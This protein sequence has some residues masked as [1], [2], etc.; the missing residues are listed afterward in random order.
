MLVLCSKILVILVLAQ[1]VTSVE[2]YKSKRVPPKYKEIRRTYSLKEEE[3]VDSTPADTFLEK[4]TDRDTSIGNIE[5]TDDNQ[6]SFTTILTNDNGG[7]ID[8]PLKKNEEKDK[9]E[10]VEADVNDNSDQAKESID[11]IQSTE[12]E[13][14]SFTTTVKPKRRPFNLRKKSKSSE[15]DI[16]V[17]NDRDKVS[18]EKI[19][20]T[21]KKQF[22]LTTSTI[23]AKRRN[24]NLRPIRNKEDK[25]P[26]KPLETF[27]K[28][29][30]DK[31]E[32]TI[33]DKQI[34]EEKKPVVSTTTIKPKR[35]F[36]DLR[37]LKN[38][39]EKVQTVPATTSDIVNTNQDKVS[40]GN[41]QTI[42]EEIPVA[43]TR[44]MKPLR[45]TLNVYS[46]KRKEEKTDSKIS[47]GNVQTTEDE[48]VIITTSTVRAKTP[49]TLGLRSNLKKK[50]QGGDSKF[51]ETVV[52]EDTYQDEVSNIQVIGD[53][54][55][56]VITSTVKPESPATS[57]YSLKR[58][59]GNTDGETLEAL[60]KENAEQGKVAIDNIQ[61]IKDKKP[62]VS[63]STIN[64]K[65]V[66][67][68][69]QLLNNEEEYIDS[70]YVE[71][72]VNENTG[73]IT[74]SLDDV[75]STGDKKLSVTARRVKPTT[76]T[77]SLYSLKKET[78]NKSV[79]TVVQDNTGQIELPLDTL[80][81]TGDNKL[82]LS[83]N[84]DTNV[85]SDVTLLSKK[86]GQNEESIGNLQAT[87]EKK[88]TVT[89]STI[90]PRRR[91]LSLSSLKRKEV[92][93]NTK[94]V[95]TQK[96]DRDQVTTSNERTTGEE[97]L[98]VT[99]ST[100]KPKTSTSS[101]YSLKKETDNKSVKTV[102][103]DN[104]GQTE[105]ALDTL[106][107]TGD[108][109][110]SLSLNKDTNV[111][112]GVT[113]FSEKT[114]QNEESIGNLQATGG[115]KD[116]VTTSTIKPRRR[117]LSLS[118]LKRKEV[119]PNAKPVSTQKTDRDQV[120]TSNERT[121]GEE[122]LRVTTS[123]V[124]PKTSTS[125]LYSLKKE[126]DNKSV[127]TVV[128]DNTGQIEL[129]LDTLKITGDNKLSL[130]LNKDTKVASVETIVNK[131]TGQ[132][133]ESTGNV[134][135]TGEKKVTIT[136][137]SIKPRRR[138]LSLSS[139]KRKE[140]H[141]DT[142]PVSTQK[143]DQ[144]QVTTSNGR[145]TGEEKLRVI[146]STVKPKTSTSSLY[147]LKKETDNK[148]V[149][150][151]VKDNTGPVELALD[152][153]KIT[154]DNKLSLSLNKDTNVASVETIV[155]KN[156]G[157]NKVSIGNV[158]ATRENK[159]T[160]TTTAI[161]P[162]TRTPNIYP[163]KRKEENS[164]NKPIA[165]PVNEN[166]DQDQVTTSDLRANGNQ[167]LSV[168]SRIMK[169][170]R[171]TS[172]LSYLK[173]TE[174]NTSSKPIETFVN[175]NIRQEKASTGDLQNSGDKKFSLISSTIEPKRLTVNLDSLKINEDN[176]KSKSVDTFVSKNFG[177]EKIS[178]DNLQS[179]KTT[180]NEEANSNISTKEPEIL[181]VN[182]AI[183]DHGSKRIIKTQRKIVVKNTDE[184]SKPITISSVSNKDGHMKVVAAQAPQSYENYFQTTTPYTKLEKTTQN[185]DNFV[186]IVGVHNYV[187]A[188][189]GDY[190]YSYEGGDGTKAFERG[191]LKSADGS[192]NSSG[193]VGGYSYKDK[194]G[195]VFNLSYTAGEGGY[196]PVGAH[197]PTSPP[198]PPAIQRVLRILAT[199]TTPEPITER[200]K[201]DH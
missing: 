19:Q 158:Q 89:T 119:N 180:I 110:L 118:S 107:T 146:T 5:T 67:L 150:T 88:V 129:P 160:V 188:Y 178:I 163:L 22:S 42:R 104:T 175:E 106:K 66:T 195:N 25:A 101:L 166:T 38:R 8:Y 10:P 20:T 40:N 59:E 71:K 142:K 154:G 201:S 102:V 177:Y 14:T 168:T 171:R 123:T 54:K 84:E 108:N 93:P 80:K 132:N 147:T 126:T 44:K 60:T 131:N 47:S 63:T 109:K 122:K 183:S 50:E 83:L 46:L 97:K 117:T 64:P 140:G 145:T 196:Q 41:L 151:F 135:A 62:I 124:K 120:T 127:K 86:T 29:N 73:Q 17:S 98:R 133:E 58:E 181:T 153:L 9:T 174:E 2:F 92:N 37:T 26:N 68:S 11:N 72:I 35:R 31:D 116:T 161:K 49:I 24:F 78:D 121:T 43:T 23:M 130:S 28:D 48:K 187:Y 111:A 138:T 192:S 95:S 186:P 167:K 32:E 157:R 128:Q 184:E 156:T 105:L 81:T 3:N 112:S 36:S 100:V 155:N 7:T 99:T 169:P 176:T 57:P 139:L 152:T 114:A 34:T 16:N 87:G 173:K 159:V 125:S 103:K 79:K 190:H 82:S 115:K 144:D 200:I 96:T 148:S 165:T 51:L 198:I 4:N 65:T 45:R 149:K 179:E 191:E 77:S 91:T 164:Q 12:N 136:T 141:S 30:I 172:N 1:Y 137:S 182:S 197:L 85:A 193:V 18:I 74:V 15:I 162:R 199:K 52:D 70:E 75:K 189:N 194:D 39:R 143:T 6:P 56:N 170:Q 21:N 90:K 13:Q 55:P 27:V 185:H 53:K 94:P 76:S 134:Q 69:P 61:I 33:D 113:L